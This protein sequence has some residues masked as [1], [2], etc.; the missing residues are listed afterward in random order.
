MESQRGVVLSSIRLGDDANAATDLDKLVADFGQNEGIAKAVRKVADEYCDVKKYDRA[1]EIYGYAIAQ[2]PEAE[3]ATESQKGTVLANTLLGDETAAQQALE[4]FVQKFRTRKDAEEVAFDLANECR[5][6]EKNKLAL[7][8]YQKVAENWPGTDEAIDSQTNT[9]KL[10]ISL[11][12]DPNSEAA[13]AKLLEDF[14]EHKL[15]TRAIED[16]ATA[17]GEMGRHEKAAELY[18]YAVTRWPDSQHAIWAQAQMVRAL[19][20][21]GDYEAAEAGLN[22]LIVRFLQDERLGEAAH[23][24]IDTFYKVGEYERGKQLYEEFV[25]IQSGDED[26]LLEFQVGVVISNVGLGEESAV[27]AGID[28]LISDFNDN[29]KL[30]KGLVQIGEKYYGRALQ[31]KNQGL[32]E[33]SNYYLGRAIAMWETVIGGLPV[34]DSTREAYYLAARA[35]MQLG[36]YGLA[37][38]YYEAVVAGWPGWSRAGKAQYLVA[39]CCHTSRFYGSGQV[40][41]EEP[42]VKTREAVEKLL[43]DYPGSQSAED[44]I[45][46]LGGPEAFKSATE[47]GEEK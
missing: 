11:R 35:Y 14:D 28:K 29:P 23:E 25:E 16:M 7:A 33:E 1:L 4:D 5:D 30:A 13:I 10:Y 43:R 47:E 8:I 46:L 39:L 9:V 45:N 32:Q 40:P 3:D 27:D 2:W 41:I 42:L 20:R 37:K 34:S 22:T 44:G 18:S 38:E 12:D 17:W 21:G 36:E 15:I 19:I 31:H 24:V 6:L 26:A